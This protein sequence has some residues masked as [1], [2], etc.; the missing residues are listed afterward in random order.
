MSGHRL[1]HTVF[2][3]LACLVAGCAARAQPTPKD[4][5]T[6]SAGTEAGRSE[7]RDLVARI[8]RHRRTIGCGTLAWDDRLARVAQRHSEDMAG[9]GYF[10]HV[11]PD[12]RDPFERMSGAGIRYHAA[13]ENLAWGQRT[14]A[15]TFDGWMSSRGHRKN[16]EACVYARIGIG[17][18]RGRW[19]CV[20]SKPAGQG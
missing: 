17:L 14:G 19:T 7:I 18:Y 13:A 1:R 3:L 6:P 11:D 5:G 2:V 8:N 10:S 16:L 9:R 4:A 20:L 15:E 12:G